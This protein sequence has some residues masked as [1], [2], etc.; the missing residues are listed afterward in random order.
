MNLVIWT[1]D[2]DSGDLV[3]IKI[4]DVKEVVLGRTDSMQ[5]QG[6]ADGTIL[7]KEV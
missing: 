7:I 6:M 2:H 4:E 3:P 1:E 5:M